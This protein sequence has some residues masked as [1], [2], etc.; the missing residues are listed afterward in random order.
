MRGSMHDQMRSIKATGIVWPTALDL[1]AKYTPDE[2]DERGQ[3]GGFRLITDVL[4]RSD[5]VIP[6]LPGGWMAIYAGRA[7]PGAVGSIFLMPNT[8]WTRKLWNQGQYKVL[9]SDGMTEDQ[10]LLFMVS[11]ERHKTRAIRHVIYLLRKHVDECS[12]RVTLSPRYGF[13]GRDDLDR[14]C[15]RHLP[16]GSYSQERVETLLNV[17][18]D[19]LRPSQYLLHEAAKLK[20]SILPPEIKED[21]APAESE[22][23][24]KPKKK[25]SPAKKEKFDRYRERVRQRRKD[26]RAKASQEP[27]EVISSDALVDEIRL[28]MDEHDARLNTQPT[29]EV[30]Q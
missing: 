16:P 8:P 30:E 24:P 15:S 6:E 29:Q 3:S 9:L 12:R 4:W 28:A 17:I 23:V 18:R 19:M 27:S 11:K 25:L 20:E 5:M 14:W 10:A 21:E 26:A 22:S 1:L 2:L 13:T 7:E